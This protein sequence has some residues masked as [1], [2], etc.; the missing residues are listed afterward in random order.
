[1]NG[2]FKIGNRVKVTKTHWRNGDLDGKTGIVKEIRGLDF[3]IEFDN[4][5]DGHNCNG[6]AKTHQGYY[7]AAPD[8]ELIKENLIIVIR[9]SNNETIAEIKEGKTVIKSA[10]ATCCPTDTYNFETGARLAF[11]RLL[12]KE[13]KKDE[14]IYSHGGGLAWVNG[15][16]VPVRK[17]EE[18]KPY[19]IVKQ[20]KYEVGDKVKIVDKTPADACFGTGMGKWLGKIMTVRR[21]KYPYEMEE[22]AGE[23]VTNDNKYLGWNW[24]QN[25]IEGKVI[26]ATYREVSRP[27][28]VGELIK[29]VKAEKG[30]HEGYDNGAVF[31]VEEM[32]KNREGCG[33]IAKPY[34]V[35]AHEY[36]VLENYTPEPKEKTI[37]DFTD[38]EV[39]ADVARRLKK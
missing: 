2:N 33:I 37:A 22:D 30:W 3:G 12:G 29:I 5:F 9:Q 19:T 39:M 27:A 6:S 15:G 23:C 35:I 31:K 8:L 18:P 17:K 16:W 32:L 28:K 10:K 38:D 14:T 26:E 25:A 21:N 34:H 36:V 20:D 1:M 7:I 11:D 4:F 24:H 13:I